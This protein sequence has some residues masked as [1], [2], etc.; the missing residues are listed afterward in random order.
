MHKRIFKTLAATALIT[1]ITGSTVFADEITDLKNEKEQVEEQRDQFEDQLAYLLVQLSDLEQNMADLSVAI[2]QADNELAAAEE[3]QQQQYEDMKLR[4]KYLYE[5]Q[6]TTF[7]EVLL[8]S[9]SMSEMLNKT[10]YVQQ[11]YDYDREKL[12]EMSNTAVE[13][14]NIKTNLEEKK[15]TLLTSQDEFLAKQALLY[16]SIADAES[17]LD[18]YNIKIEDAVKKAAQVSAAKSSTVSVSTVGSTTVGY[19][20]T[21]NNN[22]E[23]ASNIVSFA[24]SLCGIPYVYGGSTPAGF[25]CS[26]FT[27]YVFAAYGISLSRTSGGQT[28]GGTDV[29]SLSNAQ[30][31]DIICYPGH[32]GIYIGNGQ[33]I[34]APSEGDVVKVA[35][36]N[37]GLSIVGIRRYW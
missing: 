3:K 30:P 36:V 29:G 26:G 28:G 23:V 27:S 17:K 5:D 6:G 2:D 8:T 1:C 13:I 20:G 18:D 21:A 24:Y 34:H 25:D 9:S 4:I 32:V 11:V 35:S 12:T 19:T 22:S 37:I 33:M 16:Q 10:E 31:G 7:S 15:N 14:K